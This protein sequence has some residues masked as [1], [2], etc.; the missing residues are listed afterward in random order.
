MH[1]NTDIV[2]NQFYEEAMTLHTKVKVKRYAVI[3]IKARDINT[4]WAL[5]FTAIK[6]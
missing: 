4:Y 1:K 5:D 2:L 3:T 6:K